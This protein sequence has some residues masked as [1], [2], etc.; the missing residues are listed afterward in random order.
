MRTL[1]QICDLR[2]T[3]HSR[4][5]YIEKDSVGNFSISQTLPHFEL[6]AMR[7]CL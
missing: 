1:L 5:Q 7:Y 2:I 6:D 3:N 4:L